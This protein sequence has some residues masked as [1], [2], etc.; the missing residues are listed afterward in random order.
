M[1]ILSKDGEADKATRDTLDWEALEVDSE[2]ITL[3]MLFDDYERIS[4]FEEQN[5]M[6]Y[7]TLNLARFKTAEGLFIPNLSQYSSELPL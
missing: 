1:K 2:S 7:I 3:R 5:D 6:I 4:K